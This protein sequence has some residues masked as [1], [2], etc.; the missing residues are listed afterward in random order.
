MFVLG[1]WYLA[2]RTYLLVRLDKRKMGFD[3]VKRVDIINY[4]KNINKGRDDSAECSC[5]MSYRI[6]S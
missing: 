5:F 2:G 1:T 6:Q 4:H 3:A